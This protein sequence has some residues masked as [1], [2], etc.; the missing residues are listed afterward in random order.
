MNESIL[1]CPFCGAEQG[2]ERQSSKVTLRSQHR[3]RNG[4][5]MEID[6]ETLYWV[7]CGNCF[8][9][10]GNAIAGYNTL[11]QTTTTEEQAAALAIEKWNRRA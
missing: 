3:T 1:S 7:Q 9:R 4:Y 5:G 11:T 2:K 10:G 8:A 6:P